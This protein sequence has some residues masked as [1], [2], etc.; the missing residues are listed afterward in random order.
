MNLVH[1]GRGGYLEIDGYRYPITLEQGGHFCIVFP[2]GHRHNKL[3]AHLDA[4][5]AMAA[6]KQPC[7]Y[8]ENRSKLK[9][10]I[11]NVYNK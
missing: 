11:T 10:S 1:Q 8:L 4:L 5:T 6:N 9:P 7:W 2:A 3:Q